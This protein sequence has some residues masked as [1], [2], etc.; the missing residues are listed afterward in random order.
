ML[1]PNFFSC[2]RRFWIKFLPFSG[3]WY[4]SYALLCPTDHI[5]AFSVGMV[6]CICSELASEYISEAKHCL[7]ANVS[8]RL[9]QFPQQNSF[10]LQLPIEMQ[11]EIAQFLAAEDLLVARA[12]CRKVNKVL[13]DESARFWLHTRLRRNTRNQSS[14]LDSA[15]GRQTRIWIQNQARLLVYDALAHILSKIIGPR[16]NKTINR[17]SRDPIQVLRS[18]N[19]NDSVLKW[20]Y[21]NA[22]WIR[23]QKLPPLV[24]DDG[25]INITLTP[26]DVAF[27]VFY[28]MIGKDTLGI[29]VDYD[30]DFNTERIQVPRYI[31]DMVQ[32]DPFSFMAAETLSA[33]EMPNSYLVLVVFAAMT[34]VFLVQC[35]REAIFGS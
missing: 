29:I 25:S 31:Y 17:T 26:R 35:S 10:L 1:L 33:P 9:A 15:Q 3:G 5:V 23:K 27:N 14:P 12:T 30:N 2:D 6:L 4:L 28:H 19:E 16:Y 18:S 8:A 7:K 22:D 11:F 21:L 34:L 20:V 32:R 24:Q 13:K